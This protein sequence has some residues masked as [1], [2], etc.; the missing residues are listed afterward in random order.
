MVLSDGRCHD[1]TRAIAAV[2]SI[3]TG[4]LKRRPRG[5]A[6]DKG[7]DCRTFRQY[8][9]MRGIRHS[10]PERKKTKRKRGRPP[11]FHRELSSNRWKVERFFAW[12][13]NFRRLA[14][15]FERLCIM[16]LGFIQLACVMILLRNVLK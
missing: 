14:T 16:H 12:L 5:L 10:I 7:Y 4:G 8:L 11:A 3:Q 9:S 6:A 15:R 2:E 13:D 1:V